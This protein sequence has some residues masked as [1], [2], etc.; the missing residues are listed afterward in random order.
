MTNKEF[1]DII[2]RLLKPHGFKRK[3]NEWR[4]ET[5]DLIKMVDLQKSNFSNLYYLNFGYNFKG[6][7]YHGLT[8][9]I[10]SR[11]ASSD[12]KINKIIRETFDLEIPMDDITRAK[13]LSNIIVNILL[14][15][16]SSINNKADMLDFLKTKSTL[17]DI[18]L[19]VKEYLNIETQ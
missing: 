11:L 4:T 2:D 13:N 16:I 9:H 6:L 3:G 15:K 18:P 19:V 12:T 14:P 1:K 17:N 7:G 10:D 8:R 5:E